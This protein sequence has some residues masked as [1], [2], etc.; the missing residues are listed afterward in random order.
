MTR[1]NAARWRQDRW[2]IRAEVREVLCRATV[3]LVFSHHKPHSLARHSTS[4]ADMDG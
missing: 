4:E 2:P 1:H 3:L